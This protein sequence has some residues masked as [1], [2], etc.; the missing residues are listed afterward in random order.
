MHR[1]RGLKRDVI[2]TKNQ[3]DALE[4]F[5]DSKI[6][7]VTN[8]SFEIY[9]TEPTGKGSQSRLILERWSMYWSADLG[10]TVREPQGDNKTNSNNCS[11]PLEKRMFNKFCIKIPIP[12]WI[13]V[14]SFLFLL[15]SDYLTFTAGSATDVSTLTIKLQH[16]NKVCNRQTPINRWRKLEGGI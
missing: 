6:T 15:L 8:R 14:L 3:N 5:H 1:K 12:I 9:D 7:T 13:F 2:D 10:V 16:R 4:S 11:G